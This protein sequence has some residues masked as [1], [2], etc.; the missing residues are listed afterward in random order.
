MADESV[1]LGG[2]VRIFIQDGVGNPSRPYAYYGCVTLGGLNQ[3]LGTPDPIYCPSPTQRNKWDIVGRVQKTPGLGTADFTARLNRTLSDVWWDLKER[4]C[5]LNIQ[6]VIGQCQ[7]ADNF[8]SWESKI[9]IRNAQMTAFN[10]GGL[11]PMD[12]DSNAAVD[13]TGSFTFIDFNR[14]RIVR[15]A[16]Q[17]DTEILSEVID[18]FYNDF[19]QCGDCGV[20]SDGCQKLYWL[21]IANPGSPGLSSQLVYTLNGGSTWLSSD[22]ATLAGQSGTKMAAV[23]LYIVVISQVDDAHHY[24]L[25]SEIADGTGTWTR[26]GSGYVGANGPSAIYSKSPDD[27]FIAAQGGYIYHMTNPASAVTILSDGSATIQDLNAIHGKGD[28]IVA[29]GNSNAI[30]VSQNDGASFS[31]VVGPAVGVNLTAVWVMTATT[32]FVATNTALYYTVDGGVTWTQSALSSG[33]TA[34][35]DIKF[36]DSN[37][38]YVAATV[39][40]AGRVFRTTDG[41]NSWQYQSPHISGLPASA[42]INVVAPCGFNRVGAG[43]LAS[44]GTDGLVAIAA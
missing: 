17:A 1:L 42:R 21:T 43:G 3:D 18:G 35:K 15:F 44:V 14:I 12:G 7:R 9:L 40:G 32:W 31:L 16:E 23:G 24:K 13:G 29:V 4:G 2:S 19:V 10:L 30:L 37:V 26:N 20:P 38:G 6:A 33:V 41:G 27:T 22:I 5:D 28:T 39:S 11:N 34:I 8:N 25:F 36:Y